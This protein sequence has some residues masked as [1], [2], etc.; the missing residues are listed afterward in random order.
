MRS[1]PASLS[2]GSI[3]PDIERSNGKTRVYDSVSRGLDPA[4]CT[5]N[6]LK[7]FS[8]ENCLNQPSWTMFSI[9]KLSSPSCSYLEMFSVSPSALIGH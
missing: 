6:I 5:Q 2:P 8:V 9:Q 7:V 3:S 4:L 1:R